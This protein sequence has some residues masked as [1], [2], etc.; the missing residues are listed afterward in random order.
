MR[1]D[2]PPKHKRFRL[3]GAFVLVLLALL[4]SAIWSLRPPTDNF[5]VNGVPFRKWLADKPDFMIEDPIAAMGTNA[6]PSLVAVLRDRT[7]SQALYNGRLWAWNHLPKSLQAR[8]YKWYPVSGVQ[9]KR[10]AFFALRA[11][12]PEAK[13]ALPEVLR[14]SETETNKMLL[15][16]ALT[17]ALF[18]APESPETFDLWRHEWE[19]TNQLSRTDLAGYLRWSRH[20]FTA[21][22]PLLLKEAREHPGSVQVL[23]AFEF[24]GEAA[25]PAV[26]YMIEESKT[27]TFLGNMW[28]LFTRLGPVASEAVP[29]LTKALAKQD[30]YATRCLEVLKAIGPEAREALPA[31]QPLLTNSD[32]T[33][34]M[35]A[36]VAIARIK[37]KPDLAIPVLMDGLEGRLHG[38]TTSY[39]TI[40]H[41]EEPHWATS[42]PEAAE[43][44][45]GELGPAARAA[46]PVLERHLGDKNKWIRLSAAQAIWRISGQKDKALP[47][48][49]DILDKAPPPAPNQTSYGEEHEVVR[50]AEIL[51]EMGLDARDAIPSLER[52][53]P[54]SAKVR[55]AVYRAL[56]RINQDAR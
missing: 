22:A 17:T 52:V 30:S 55:R 33:V 23:E 27:G 15:A 42:G 26:P 41:R 35:L 11:L 51:E 12:G 24:L 36:A 5:Q 34:V 16:S 49:K 50:A 2:P 13:A 54:F 43:I 40:E 14:V 3:P 9:L 6:I 53:R 18:I 20:P 31:I 21:A 29:E 19:H 25:R 10:T 32:P 28:E 8:Y 44:L 47:A 1:P 37:G 38:K 46:L 39:I 56:A 48:L 45:I 7:E 4:I